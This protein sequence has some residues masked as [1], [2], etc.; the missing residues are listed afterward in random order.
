MHRELS[1]PIAATGALSRAVIACGFCNFDPFAAFVQS[2]PYGRTSS[3]EDPRAVLQEGR[4]TCS[5][6]HQL[7]AALAHECNHFEVLLTVGLYKMCE[8]NTPGVGSVLRRAS[9]PFVPEAHCYLTV[10]SRRYDFTGLPKG[11]CSPLAAVYEEHVVSPAQ[12]VEFKLRL[13][14]QAI[15]SWA[16][17]VGIAAAAA[18]ATR[19]NCIAA[20]AANPAVER[21]SLGAAG[22]PTDAAHVER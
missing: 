1:F 8:E 17:S 7:L 3:P 2:L 15:A 16:G 6:K 21:T 19:E 4:G 12:L 10:D 22:A 5:S 11:S 14:K 20:L 13:H 18:W 9:L